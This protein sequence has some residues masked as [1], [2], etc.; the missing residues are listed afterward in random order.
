VK[1]SKRS[2]SKKP[3]GFNLESLLKNLVWVLLVPIMGILSYV[4]QIRPALLLTIGNY[5]TGVFE[6]AVLGFAVL[7]FIIWFSLKK[8]KKKPYK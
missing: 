3:T 1:N 7:A 4:T 6:G 5:F 8:S 2:H